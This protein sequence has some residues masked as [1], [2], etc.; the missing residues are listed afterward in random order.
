MYD[1]YFSKN[2]ET[3]LANNYIRNVNEKEKQ[4]ITKTLEYCC[5]IKNLDE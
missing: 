4:F 1:V 3:L 2:I 5:F